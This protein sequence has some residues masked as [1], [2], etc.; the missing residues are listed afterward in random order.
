VLLIPAVLGVYVT[1]VLL[2]QCL[3]LFWSISFG[4]FPNCEYFGEILYLIAGNLWH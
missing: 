4:G 3:V 1:F 2:G